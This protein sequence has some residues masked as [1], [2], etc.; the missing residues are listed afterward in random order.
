MHDGHAAAAV[1]RARGDIDLATAPSLR[2]A[3]K[4]ALATH[5]EVVLDLSQVTFMDCAGLG[6]L[7]DARNQADRCGGR[8]LLRGAGRPVARLLHLT[9]LQ[10][11]LTV[12]P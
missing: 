5:R 10:R 4:A 3:L 2:S 11:R 7:V 12:E 6:A 9:G 8:L 1:V